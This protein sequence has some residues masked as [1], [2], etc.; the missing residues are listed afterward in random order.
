[1]NGDSKISNPFSTGSGGAHFEAHV[2]ASFVILMLAGGFA[3]C[4]P[5]WPIKKIKL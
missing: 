2:Q 1:M 4:M 3:P 5:N